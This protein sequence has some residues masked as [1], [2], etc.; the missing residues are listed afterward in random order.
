MD[1]SIPIR[2]VENSTYQR[3]ELSRSHCKYKYIIFYLRKISKGMANNTTNR[4]Q[5]F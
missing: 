5:L 1:Q 2:V 4:D 3:F